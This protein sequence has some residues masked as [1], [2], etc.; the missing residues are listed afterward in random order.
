MYDVIRQ[1]LSGV[2]RHEGHSSVNVVPVLGRIALS[3]F[4]KENKMFK[5][6]FSR[7]CSSLPLSQQYGNCFWDEKCYREEIYPHLVLLITILILRL[8]GCVALAILVA[9]VSKLLISPLQAYLDRRTDVCPTEALI[10]SLRLILGSCTSIK[11]RKVEFDL[12]NSGI[13]RGQQQH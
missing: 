11:N 6:P 5:L 12:P 2:N 9:Y 4:V 10:Q 13:P 8:A 7:S 3:L 1:L